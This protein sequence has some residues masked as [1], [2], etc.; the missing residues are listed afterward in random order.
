MEITKAAK[1]AQD[2]VMREY[3]TLAAGKENISVKELYELRRHVRQKTNLDKSSEELSDEQK[4]WRELYLKLDGALEK[5]V[6]SAEKLKIDKLEND[7]ELSRSIDRAL[8]NPDTK[9][10][11]DYGPYII[12]LALLL[13]SIVAGIITRNILLSILYGTILSVIAFFISA[14]L[15]DSF[16][17]KYNLGIFLLFISKIIGSASLFKFGE[18]LCSEAIGLDKINK[19]SNQ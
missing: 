14:F 19:E 18:K 16:L 8:K 5:A 9:D 12:F 15:F 11:K 7:L 13:G 2:K 3:N 17:A 6:G 10:K 4:V 1:E